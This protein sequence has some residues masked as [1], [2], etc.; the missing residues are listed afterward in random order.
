MFDES[1]RESVA[2]RL[3]SGLDKVSSEKG[4]WLWTKAKSDNGYGKISTGSSGSDYV[5]RVA[6][7]IKFGE[8]PKGA[9]VC[10]HCDNPPCANP[11]H[12]FLGTQ[13]ENMQDAARKGRVHI[14]TQELCKRGTHS[15]RRR[16]DLLRKGI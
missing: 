14:R 11:D 3:L 7:A 13:K 2:A 9:F 15:V 8:I 12:L 1:S 6:Y 5:H 16:L 10:H 4:C